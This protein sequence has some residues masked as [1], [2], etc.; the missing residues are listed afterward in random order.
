MVSTV[1]VFVYEYGS[2]G[3]LMDKPM[4]NPLMYQGEL[5]LRALISDLVTLPGIDIITA[6]DSRL[7]SLELPASV[8]VVPSDGQPDDCFDDCLLA[9]D[10]VWPIAPENAGVLERLSRKIAESRRIL[11]GSRPDA[12]RIASSRMLTARTLFRA[13]IPVADTY[14]P[15]DV[16]PDHADAWVAKS[17]DGVGFSATQIFHRVKDAVAW[18]AESSDANYVLQPFI[19]GSPCSISLLCC[20]GVV[21]VLSCDEQRIA[22]RNNQFHYL[23]TRVN[24]MSNAA[25]ECH[26]LARMIAAAVP[27]LWGYVG[28]DFIMTKTGPVVLGIC[29]RITT[30]YAGLHASIG[31]NPA[32]LVL[33]LLK[34]KLGADPPP[35]DKIVVNVDAQVFSTR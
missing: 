27:G 9:A 15:D 5:M 4:R 26:R 31:R 30:S 2:C 1:K 13:G 21:H 18:I 32:A 23:G 22:V 28:V 14:L 33:D 24:S 19:R 35:F 34:T 20:E 6:R 12:V 16:L 25:V 29:P 8:L 10:A 11:L 17:D 3:G 7:P